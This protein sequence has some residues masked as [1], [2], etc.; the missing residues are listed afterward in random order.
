MRLD[1]ETARSRERGLLTATEEELY[2]T[3]TREAALQQRLAELEANSG[4]A[5]WLRKAE[6]LDAREARVEAR[7]RDAAHREAA[8]RQAEASLVEERLRL[9]TGWTAGATGA[10]ASPVPAA[11]AASFASV[12]GGGRLRRMPAAAADAPDTPSATPAVAAAPAADAAA[13]SQAWAMESAVETM[14]W[15]QHRS[16]RDTPPSQQVHAT[17]GPLPPFSGRPASPA[18][19]LPDDAVDTY[20]YH[21]LD[22]ISVIFTQYD[23]ARSGHISRHDL[24]HGIRTTPHFR[25]NF[26]CYDHLLHLIDSKTD[27]KLTYAD[28][29]H[30]VI[31]AL[32]QTKP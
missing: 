7:E 27:M 30:L 32:R 26:P 20:I 21:T 8:A 19:P 15:A 14:R 6:L 28:C 10:V 22:R 25:K 2:D 9:A 11:S 18:A 3:L 31:K 4:F 13:V 5:Y 23:R 29:K 16:G 12:E 24:K 17:K 1:A